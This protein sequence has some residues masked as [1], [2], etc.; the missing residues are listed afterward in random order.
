MEPTPAQRAELEV[1]DPAVLLDKLRHAGPGVGASVVGFKC[2]D[3]PRGVVEAHLAGRY[4]ADRNAREQAD[5]AKARREIIQ[6]WAGVGSSA[7]RD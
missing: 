7:S 6:L 1:S 4:H 3:I 5:R 2:G